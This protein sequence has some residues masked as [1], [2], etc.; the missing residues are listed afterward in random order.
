MKP[1]ECFHHLPL[2]LKRDQIRLLK[3]PSRRSKGELVQ[4]ELVH[5]DFDTLPSYTGEP[6]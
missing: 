5:V 3:L 2:D 1:N 4:L 6:S